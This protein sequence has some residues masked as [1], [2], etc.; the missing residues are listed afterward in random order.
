MTNPEV[1]RKRELKTCPVCGKTRTA[2]VR[3]EATCR[4]CRARLKRN[5]EKNYV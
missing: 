3:A 2:M 4:N 5:R 1:Y